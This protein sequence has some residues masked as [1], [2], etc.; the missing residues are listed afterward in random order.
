MPGSIW[1]DRNSF[2]YGRLKPIRKSCPLPTLPSRRTPSTLWGLL[3][4]LM[5]NLPVGMA[6]TAV[7]VVAMTVTKM[8][9]AVWVG[10]V[11]VTEMVDVETERQKHADEERDAGYSI[12]EDWL[13]H[14][15]ARGVDGATARAVSAEILVEV[16]VSIC[17][18]DAVAVAVLDADQRDFEILEHCTNAIG[19]RVIVVVTTGTLKY[20]LQNGLGTVAL[21]T[22][23]RRTSSLL[24]ESAMAVAAKVLRKN[25]V[26]L[27]WKKRK[28]EYR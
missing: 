4:A 7:V 24:Q 18:K 20:E 12:L 19:V 3:L 16:H 14:A 23:Q 17:V 21:P 22:R 1:K 27:I 10:I 9:I 11:A 8:L 28:S 6:G 25:I 26:D 15:G 2:S 13:R 5:W